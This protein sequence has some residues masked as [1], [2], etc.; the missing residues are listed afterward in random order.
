MKIGRYIR[1]YGRWWKT[2]N[3]KELKSKKGEPRHFAE[4]L[5]IETGVTYFSEASYHYLG[6]LLNYILWFFSAK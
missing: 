3:M 4:K 5:P 1:K 6:E 2:K